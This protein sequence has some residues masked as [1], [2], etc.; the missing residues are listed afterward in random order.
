MKI[1]TIAPRPRA[2]LYRALVAKEAAIRQG[3]RGTYARVGRKVQG[4][5]KWKHKKFKGSVQL[6]H[7]DAE[8]VTA[9]V[10]ASTAEDERRLL[11]SFLGF[12]DRHAGDDVDT[13]TI[14]YR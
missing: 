11:S 10:R 14:Q 12:I 6:A 1:V 8:I 4:S 13:I 5:T 3:G 2:R 7:G 9:K